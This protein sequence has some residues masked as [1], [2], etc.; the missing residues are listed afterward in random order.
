MAT[1]ALALVQ[2]RRE[3]GLTQ[4][5]VADRAGVQRST[6][7]RLETGAREPG[8]ETLRRLAMALM[9]EFAFNPLGA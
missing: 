4:Q 7:A 5:Q 2:A 8:A 1:F 9:V 6:V 3:A